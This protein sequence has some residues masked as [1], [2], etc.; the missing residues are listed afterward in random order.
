MNYKKK[1][2]DNNP[3]NSNINFNVR[4][5]T[6]GKI[7]APSI[8]AADFSNLKNGIEKAEIFGCEYLHIDIMDGHFV[9]NIS[10]GPKV[11]KDIKKK[12]LLKLDTHL[13]IDDPMFFL[14]RFID[15]GSEII[16]F[17]YEINNKKLNYNCNDVIKKIKE[18]NIKAGISIKPKTDVKE[19]LNLLDGIDL[20]LIMTVEPGFS[21][22]KMIESTLTK[23]S[24]LK[25]LRVKNNYKFIIEVDGGI[26]FK[27]YKKIIELGADLLVMGS[28]FFS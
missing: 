6:N 28:A 3:H 10:F 17:H 4:T 23:I 22:Q 26:N 16:T 1:I 5:N 21:G 9:P 14:D 27:N 18:K 19:I 25:E 2:E 8:F 7:I 20:V 24:Y 15:A 11:V 12:T 13:M